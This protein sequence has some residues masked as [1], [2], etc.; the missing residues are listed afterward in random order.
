MLS[1]CETNWGKYGGYKVEYENAME[2]YIVLDK[3]EVVYAN[4][5]QVERLS[6]STV[7]T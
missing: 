1:S 3:G 7:V 5:T 4:D 2:Y 6:K